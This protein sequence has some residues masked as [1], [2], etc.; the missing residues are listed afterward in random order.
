MNIEHDQLPLS[1][2]LSEKGIR[3]PRVL[4]AFDRVPRAAFVPEELRSEAEA[5]R[6][7]Q[8]GF[9][10]TISQPYI[11]AAMTCALKLTSH[12][13]V[14]E[15]GTGSGYQTAILAE[16]LPK[17]A[18]LRTI[19]LIP[20]LLCRARETLRRLGYD[21]IEF[22]EGDGTLGWPE[23]APFDAILVAAA[24]ERLPAPLLDQLAPGGRLVIPVGPD[25]QHQQL[26]LWTR[27]AGGGALR[28]EV[29]MPVRFVP[30]LGPLH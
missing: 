20:E 27:A 16:L 19:E 23:A 1:R 12:A 18:V 6:A 14:L 15:V 25:L 3:D 5:D 30:L 10:Q 8:I 29:L 28:R 9:E 11:V 22:R 24:P 26:E 13:R 4:A 7:L 21:R 2:K 17:R